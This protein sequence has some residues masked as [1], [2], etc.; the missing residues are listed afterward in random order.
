[1]SLARV[2]SRAAV[3]VDAPEVTV[4][5]HAGGGLPRVSMVG[6]PQTAVRE[7]KDR[8][9]AALLNA[10]FDFPDGL[11]TISLAPADL[12][13]EGSRFD[14]PIALGILAASGQVFDRR[15]DETEFIGELSLGGGLNPVRGVLPVAIQAGARRACLRSWPGSTGVSD[16]RKRGHYLFRR[17]STAKTSPTFT[18]RPARGALW[19]WLLPECT[20]CCSAARPAPAKPCW[21]LDYR[22]SCR[23][24]RN[25]RH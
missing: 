12:P 5:V 6:L 11:I 9:K 25:R 15:F 8:V 4:E 24:W 20:T 19:K 23:L 2:I 21:P 13:K 17:Q 3:G 7:S 14:L 22:V 10:G 16:W 1:M 18:D